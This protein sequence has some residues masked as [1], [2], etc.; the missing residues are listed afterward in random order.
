MLQYYESWRRPGT[1][2]IETGKS[3]VLLLHS[4]SCR[5]YKPIANLKRKILYERRYTER[6]LRTRRTEKVAFYL[7]ESHFFKEKHAWLSP[8]VVTGEGR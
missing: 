3:L 6:Y 5:H 7:R 1:G 4:Q 2:K 8:L